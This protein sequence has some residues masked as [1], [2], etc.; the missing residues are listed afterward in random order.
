MSGQCKY[1]GSGSLRFVLTAFLIVLLSWVIQWRTDDVLDAIEAN[2]T[3]AAEVQ[4]EV[5]G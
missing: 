5:E 2:C 1:S 3:P 4:V